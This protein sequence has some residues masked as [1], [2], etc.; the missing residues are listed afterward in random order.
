MDD[1]VKEVVTGGR[2]N[3]MVTE[4]GISDIVSEGMVS[5]IVTR[6]TV[7]EMAIKIR[8]VTLGIISVIVMAGMLKES[9]INNGKIWCSQC[10]GKK[11]MV[12]AMAKGRVANALEG[13][14][15]HSQNVGLERLLQKDGPREYY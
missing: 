10:D 15:S 8:S 3:G 14:R 7:N 13:H 9:M 1:L 12:N 2:I 11:G 5:E 6:G 4:S